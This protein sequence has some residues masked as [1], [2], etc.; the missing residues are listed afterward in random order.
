MLQ[1]YYDGGSIGMATL[2][3]RDQALSFEEARLRADDVSIRKISLADLWQS[4]REGYKDYAVTPHSFLLI[5]F[6]YFLVALIVTL[7]W[8]GQ[9][10]RYLAFPIVAGFTLIGPIIAVAFFEMS[11]RQELGLDARW[12]AAFGFIHTHSFAPILALSL[13]MALLYT[14]WVYMAQMIYFG[15]LGA[16]PPASLAEFVEQLVS[17]RTGVGLIAYGNLVGFVFACGVLAASIVSFSL[18][19]DK[20]VTAATALTVSVKAF[21]ANVYVLAVWGLVVA[22]LLLL[23]TALL[24]IG[25]AFILPILG[26][27][28]WHLYR[29]LID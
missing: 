22:V 12:S 19:L 9:E 23:G 11:R 6:F 13:L 29:K 16:N 18:A 7:S 2:T 4:L 5:A 1:A 24:L 10:L 15:T 14:G 28:T 8:S 20:P 3:H 27:A 26:H 21:T 25:L 17:T